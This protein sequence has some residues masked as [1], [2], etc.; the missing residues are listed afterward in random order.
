MFLIA[1][2]QPFHLVKVRIELAFQQP[3]GDTGIGMDTSE[4]IDDIAILDKKT[5]KILDIDFTQKFGMILDIDPQKNNVRIFLRQRLEC[6]PPSAAGPAPVGA[7][8]G[9]DP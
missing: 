3:L 7:K 2:G 9:N 8:A 1:G 4:K 5:R 6:R